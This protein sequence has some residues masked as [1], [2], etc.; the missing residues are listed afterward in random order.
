MKIGVL[1]LGYVGVVNLACFS[2]AGYTVYCTDVKKIKVHQVREG[3]SPIG[4]PEVDDLLARGIEAGTIIPTES[5]Q[6]NYHS[7]H[8][9]IDQG[10]NSLPRLCF[11]WPDEGGQ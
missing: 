8:Q 11:L 3:K 1:G 4:E 2:K 6:S 10:R 9:G 5:P 7:D